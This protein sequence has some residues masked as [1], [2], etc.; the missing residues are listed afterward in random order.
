MDG[1]S[2]MAI[3]ESKGI[4]FETSPSKC[5]IFFCS[6]KVNLEILRKLQLVAFERRTQHTNES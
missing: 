4:G 3:V 5:E 2:T 1:I 6:G